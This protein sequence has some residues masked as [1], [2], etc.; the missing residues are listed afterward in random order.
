MSYV[1]CV[2]KTLLTDWKDMELPHFTVF[3]VT[4]ASLLYCS[5]KIGEILSRV[6]TRR[7][8]QRLA[9]LEELH[10]R[11]Q[12]EIQTAFDLWWSGEPR[13]TVRQALLRRMG[14]TGEDIEGIPSG[15]L[16][17]L[18]KGM[19]DVCREAA[20][21]LAVHANMAKSEQ[22]IID[23]LSKIRQVRDQIAALRMKRD[24]ELE[25]TRT[26][27]VSVGIDID[28]LEAYFAS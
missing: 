20:F 27:L 25:R 26:E 23:E 1:N 18:I 12:R 3:V 2:R 17:V 13:K 28:N 5:E 6:V 9:A 16:D 7:L 21:Y 8:L 19:Y 11:T 10:R 14:L 15:E 24:N 22:A 4:L